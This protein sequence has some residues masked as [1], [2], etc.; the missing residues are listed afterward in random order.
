[1]RNAVCNDDGHGPVLLHDV[2]AAVRVSHMLCADPQG[3]FTLSVTD[4]A[5]A[6]GG[7]KHEMA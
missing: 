2:G 3:C 4:A 5:C 1:V 7:P 6:T